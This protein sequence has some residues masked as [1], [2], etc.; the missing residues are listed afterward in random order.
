MNDL[1]FK[2]LATDFETHKIKFA[3]FLGLFVLC[4]GDAVEA[5]SAQRHAA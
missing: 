4:S 1:N 2:T 3:I 5:G